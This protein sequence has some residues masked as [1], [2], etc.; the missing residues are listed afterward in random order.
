MDMREVDISGFRRPDIPMGRVR[1]GSDLKQTD[2]ENEG[3][4]ARLLF[5]FKLLCG[6]KRGVSA[7]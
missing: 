5:C 3:R 1:Q 7:F 2:I 4:Y 6:P